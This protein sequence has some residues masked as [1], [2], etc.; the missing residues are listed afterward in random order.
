MS[1]QLDCVLQE[2]RLPRG[3]TVWCTKKQL[4]GTYPG[5]SDLIAL[6]YGLSIRGCKG[7]LD[8]SNMCQDKDILI[9]N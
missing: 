7:S 6:R 9:W 1:L 5:D 8:G 3:R 4:Q 2:G